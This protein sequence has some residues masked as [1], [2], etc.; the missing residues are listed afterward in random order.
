MNLLA[1]ADAPMSTRSLYFI[2]TVLLTTLFMVL[3]IL[4]SKQ[5]SDV[6]D[7]LA[8]DQKSLSSRLATMGAAW[9]RKY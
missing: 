7:V 3:A 8:D 4:K 5:L 9:R 2:G 1:A 6:M